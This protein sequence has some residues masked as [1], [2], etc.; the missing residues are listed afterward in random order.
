MFTFGLNKF[1][2]VEILK[3]AYVAGRRWDINLKDEQAWGTLTSERKND[4]K[5]KEES[6]VKVVIKNIDIVES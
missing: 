5:A 6:Y 4:I 2:I 3:D 1:H